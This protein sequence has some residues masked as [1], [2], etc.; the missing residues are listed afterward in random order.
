MNCDVLDAWSAYT[1]LWLH[2]SNVVSAFTSL[3]PF[4][5]LRTTRN[6]KDS[7]KMKERCF[8]VAQWNVSKKSATQT[9]LTI[10]F[11]PRIT[12]G[13]KGCG[14][15]GPGNNPVLL[16]TPSASSG[17]K[18]LS[19]APRPSRCGFVATTTGRT[20][21][22][23]SGFHAGHS[24]FWPPIDFR[25]RT[26]RP[27]SITVDDTFGSR[28]GEKAHG[29]SLS[30][31]ASEVGGRPTSATSTTT[32]A[33]SVAAI[34]DDFSAS[35]E[36]SGS[37]APVGPPPSRCEPD[38]IPEKTTEITVVREYEANAGCRG[39]KR[40]S[41]VPVVRALSTPRSQRDKY[42]YLLEFRNVERTASRIARE[43]SAGTRVS[44]WKL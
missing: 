29:S 8:L 33:A 18:A 34:S 26:L 23:A 43:T 28:H 13:R 21:D 35:S 41:L 31:P 19:P 4:E 15:R 1:L 3:F 16:D 6:S 37:P 5:S 7:D 2:I 40:R 22:S 12:D 20:A 9:Q 25:G 32:G 17:T 38:S 44:V 30:S 27:P 11:E 14:V 39:E 36:A 24:A 42:R 10:S